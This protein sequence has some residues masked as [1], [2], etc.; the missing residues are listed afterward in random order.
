LRDPKITNVRVIDLRF[1][2]SS[3]QIGSDAVN[4]DPDYSAAYCI[5]ETDA[6]VEG[7][8]LTFTLGRGNELCVSA[9]KYLCRFVQGRHLSSLT[10]DLAAFSRQLTGDTQFRWLGPEK[11]V[12]HLAAA[13]LINAV[14]DLYARVEGKPLW[15]LLADTE[16]EQ[17]VRAIDFTYITDAITKEEALDLLKVRASCK[18]TRLQYLRQN[19][20]PA[21][22]TSAGWI[23]YSD[24]KIRHLCGEALAQGWTHFKLKVGGDPADDLRRAHLVRAEIGSGNK[25]I[26]DA[27]QKWG[28]L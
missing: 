20:Y 26:M 7:H 25:L 27:N 11:G 1:P 10:V 5:L 2:T 4:R 8:G 14:W 23:G 15:K 16:P 9:L 6:G 19:G 21:Y 22:T 17:I 18:D 13:A 28:V 12:I 24:D 3:Q